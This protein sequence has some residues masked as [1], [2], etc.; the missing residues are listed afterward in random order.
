LNGSNT[1][2]DTIKQALGQIDLKKLTSLV[3]GS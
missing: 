3:S 2:M 1:S